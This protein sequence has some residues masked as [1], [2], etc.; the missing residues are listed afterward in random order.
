ERAK[1]DS[2]L[3]RLQE[4]TADSSFGE[5]AY[6]SLRTLQA[7]NAYE[8][9]EVFYADLELPDSAGF[10][11]RKAL[12]SFK[13]SVKT[14][15]ILYVLAEMH[16]SSS[17]TTRMTQ[18]HLYEQIIAQYPKS[19]YAARARVRLGME[20]ES[21]VIDSAGYVYQR[22]ERTIEQGEYEAA[23][24]ELKSIVNAY[25][26]SPF[27]AKSAYAVGWLYEH[28]LGK[29]D[30][31]LAQYNSLLEHFSDT[32]YASLLRKR[33]KPAAAAAPP[34]TLRENKVPLDEFPR[35]DTPRQETRPKPPVEVIE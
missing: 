15:R 12:T 7:E 21:P 32:P 20:V 28:R 8:L 22:A 5:T 18:E 14:P 31:A 26:F 30:S 27:A 29:P 19:Q 4:G 2:I 23:I 34:D 10:W 1:R 13:D 35:K 33:L 16:Q 9:G 25:P 6:D 3:I 11:Y 24:A 17:E